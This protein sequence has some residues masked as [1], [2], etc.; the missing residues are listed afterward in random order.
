MWPNICLK[1]HISGIWESHFWNFCKDYNTNIATLR[2]ST[3]DYVQYD[4]SR[5]FVRLDLSH[6][7]VIIWVDK[8]FDS[9]YW[10]WRA[11]SDSL[12]LFFSLQRSTLPLHGCKYAY[13]V[14]WLVFL[15]VH[16]LPSLLG[17]FLTTCTSKSLFKPMHHIYMLDIPGM[18]Q[19]QFSI[20]PKQSTSWKR[21]DMQAVQCQT[22]TNQGITLPYFQFDLTRP[23]S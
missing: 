18:V 12:F 3:E 16:E 1:S 20:L 13:V 2:Y 22:P 10:Q 15:G 6:C 9:V 17:H 4:K 21:A 8:V 5:I 19:G 23:R 11:S 14:N 7:D